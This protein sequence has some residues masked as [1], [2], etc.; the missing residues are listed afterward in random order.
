MLGKE[1][2]QI[3]T[4]TNASGE[5]KEEESERVYRDREKQRLLKSETDINKKKLDQKI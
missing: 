2:S 4:R 3:S 5:K 1:T